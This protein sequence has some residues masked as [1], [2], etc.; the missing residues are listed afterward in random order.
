MNKWGNRSIAGFTTWPLQS[1]RLNCLHP[2]RATCGRH[3]AVVLWW[4]WAC[5]LERPICRCGPAE[6]LSLRS[7]SASSRCCPPENASSLHTHTHTHTVTHVRHSNCVLRNIHGFQTTTQDLSVFPFA[8]RHYHMTCVLLSPFITTVWTPQ[9]GHVNYVYNDDDDDIVTH[10]RRTWRFFPITGTQCNTPR[11][12]GQAEWVGLENTGMIDLLKVFTN[13]STNRAQRSSTL[14]T[15]PTH[16]H[17]SKTSHHY[18][19]TTTFFYVF[20]KIN[21]FDLVNLTENALL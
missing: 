12:D 17:H 4:R 11:R 19:I 7:Q 14:L 2:T 21:A 1:G 10:Q 3:A 5:C 9:I 13:P 18:R 8:P 6:L 20:R 16:Y 15:W